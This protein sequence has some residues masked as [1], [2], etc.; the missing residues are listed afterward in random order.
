M[1]WQCESGLYLTGWKQSRDSLSNP[2][3][4]FFLLFVFLVSSSLNSFPILVCV[5]Q[6]LDMPRIFWIL[7][8]FGFRFLWFLYKYMF[9]EEEGLVRKSCSLWYIFI[10]EVFRKE[11]NLTSNSYHLENFINGF[12]FVVFCRNVGYKVK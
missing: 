3:L 1:Y 4:F 12:M 10:A 9:G 8:G 6:T 5:L 11:E 2:F 7:E